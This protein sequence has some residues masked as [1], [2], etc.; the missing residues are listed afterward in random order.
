LFCI[1]KNIYIFVETLKQRAMRKI[2]EYQLKKVSTDFTKVQIKSSQMASEY[3]RQFYSDDL[4]IYESCFL[5]LLNRANQ[6]IGY[7]KIS[8][9]GIVGTVIDPKLVFKYVIESLAT[10]FILC[11]NHPSGQL[12]PSE[13]DKRITQKIKEASKLLDVDFLDH[14]ILTEETYYS[15]ADNADF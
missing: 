1:L 15:M 6:T 3:I 7:A 9:G 5:L 10:A 2:K 11:H 12:N 4:G 8:Q 13:D 14:I